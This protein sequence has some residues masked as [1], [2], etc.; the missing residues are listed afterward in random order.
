MSISSSQPRKQEPKRYAPQEAGLSG[1]L[2]DQVRDAIRVKHYSLRTEHTY[3]QWVR[4][5]VGFHRRHP[6]ALD[7][8][9]VRDFLTYLAR[10]GT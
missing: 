1:T 6:A 4:Q 2:F 10:D 9:E 3:L 8:Q 5:F 7:A